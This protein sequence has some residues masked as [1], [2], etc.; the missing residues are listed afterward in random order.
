ML[1]FLSCMKFKVC[2]SFPERNARNASLKK[3]IQEMHA[4]RYWALLGAIG[5]QERN[6][7]PLLGYLAMAKAA[8]RSP[9]D[10]RRA[11]RISLYGHVLYMFS[12]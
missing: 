5:R 9:A 11:I 8:G 6:A 1:A 2:I 3:E 4:P 12:R 10:K 7:T